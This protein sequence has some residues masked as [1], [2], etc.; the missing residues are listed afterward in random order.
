MTAITPRKIQAGYEPIA[1]YVLEELIGRGGFGEVWRAEAPGGI[2]KAVKFVFGD[3]DEHRAEQ[4][5]K[6]LERIKGVQH[7]FILTLERFEIVD[8][9]LVIVTELADGSLDDIFKNRRRQGSCGIS[10]PTLLNYM[11]DTADALDYLHDLY[12]LQHLDIKPANLLIVGG[13]VKVDIHFVDRI[14]S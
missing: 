12:K 7:P 9:R 8:D 13:R 11:R 14:A 2:K 5:L 4:E 10:R 1:G 3:R 6:S